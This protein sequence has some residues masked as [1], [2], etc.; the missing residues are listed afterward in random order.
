MGKLRTLACLAC[1]TLLQAG[2][3]ISPGLHSPSDGLDWTKI[4]IPPPATGAIYQ[5]G[6]ELELAGN[7]V[8][9]HVGDIVTIV[10]D[11]QTAAQKTATTAT[12]KTT[13]DSLPGPTLLG[14]SVTFHGVP[15]LDNN[16]NNSAKFSGQGDSAQSNSLTGYVACTVVRVLPNGDL[17][18]A[19]QKQVGLNQGQEYLRLSGIIRPID[20]AADDSIPSYGVTDAE[21]SYV[22]KGAQADAN[23]QSWLAHLFNS[24]WMPF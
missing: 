15:V 22:G 8:A 1:A 2:C 11:E 6:R 18:V 14:K 10:L 9:R 17:V 23:R 19:G 20:L 4:Q 5:Q 7:P 16:I 12:Q 24:P 3:G 21:I 13:T